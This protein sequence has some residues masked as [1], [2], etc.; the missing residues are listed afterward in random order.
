MQKKIIAL[1]VAAAFSAPAFADVTANGIVD[2]AIISASGA[3][4]K[5][6]IIAYSGGLSTS[7]L[8]VT[9]TEGLDNGWTVI[10]NVEYGIDTQDNA[11]T[12]TA[13]KKM[14]AV[15]GGFGT[16]ATGYL[17]TTGYDMA[18]KFDP[19]SSLSD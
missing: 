5:S 19:T 17:Q 4:Q 8:S 18:V 11:S 10:G 16:V 12:L 14:L 6:D 2:G 1:A 13:R 3:G 9:A 15:A 7:R